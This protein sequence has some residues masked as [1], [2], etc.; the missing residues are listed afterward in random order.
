[1]VEGI[2]SHIN[3]MELYLESLEA[4]IEEDLKDVPDIGE[5]KSGMLAM[6]EQL[7]Y[8]IAQVAEKFGF[9]RSWLL[10]YDIWG[11]TTKKRPEDY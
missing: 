10:Q 1:M 7:D 6:C 2:L 8:S 5:A 9:K 3:A 4:I 11:S